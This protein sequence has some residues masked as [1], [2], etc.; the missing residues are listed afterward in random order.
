V[1]QQGRFLIVNADDF[2]QD[3]GIN[4]GIITAHQNGIVT[5]AS[6]MVGWPAAG[7]AVHYVHTRGQDLG[8]GLHL[9][10][11]EWRYA[12]GDWIARYSVVPVRDEDAVRAEVERQID[13]FEVLAGFPPTHIDSHQHV[14]RNHPVRSVV[15]RAAEVLAVPVRSETP[16]IRYEGSFYGQTETGSPL[17]ENI[18]SQYLIRLL[19]QVGG[20]VTELGCHPGATVTVD[21]SYRDERR[22]ELECLTSA[23]VAQSVEDFGI[24][25][26][27]FGQLPDSA[28]GEQGTGRS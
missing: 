23:S 10:L 15:L 11:G 21:T 16:G 20:G 28:L 3:A 7:E 27:H 19:R 6:L 25:L 5:S 13:A 12:D 8:L 26:I 24:E 22:R 1:T 18:T 17:P 4:Q 2:G 9:D 14:H